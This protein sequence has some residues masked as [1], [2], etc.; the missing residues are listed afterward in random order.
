MDRQDSRQEQQISLSDG[1]LESNGPFSDH[2]DKVL[3]TDTLDID[4]KD[5]SLTPISNI[6]V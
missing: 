5:N 1:G 4:G 2:V 3:E 6:V